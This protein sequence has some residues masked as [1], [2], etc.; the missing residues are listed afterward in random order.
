M[1]KTLHLLASAAVLAAFVIAAP[2]A[3]ANHDD[4]GGGGRGWPSATVS[5][6]DDRPEAPLPLT[7][8]GTVCNVTGN[9]TTTAYEGLVVE[10]N[11]VPLVSGPGPQHATGESVEAV[12]NNPSHTHYQFNELVLQCVGEISGAIAVVADGGNDGH[13]GDLGDPL[14]HPKN[15]HHG[16]VNLSA[17]SNQSS[18]SHQC[19]ETGGNVNKGDI[20]GTIGTDTAHGWVKY[21]RVGT[22][23]RA[24]GTFE[25]GTGPGVGKSFTAELVLTP[26]I[27]LTGPTGAFAIQGVSLLD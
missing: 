11:T 9:V 26:D 3:Q 16:S 4:G 1:R 27:E 24:W 25:C 14:N 22:L 13:L 8:A 7:D 6:H 20:S 5:T 21:D 18:Y 15:A 17:W 10:G 2:V 12:N 19:G 23:V